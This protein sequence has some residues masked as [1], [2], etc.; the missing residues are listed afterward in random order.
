[1]SDKT[2]TGSIIDLLP[3][4]MVAGMV[5]SLYKKRKIKWYK[6][7]G[8]KIKRLWY[9]ITLKEL[10]DL[11]IIYIDYEPDLIKFISD[12]IWEDV[13]DAISDLKQ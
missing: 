3:I 1:M 4:C 5:S 9:Q 8:Y 2:T 12:I 7:L 6:R 11:R 10:D 13:F